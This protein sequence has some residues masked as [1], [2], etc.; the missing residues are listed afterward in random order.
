[1]EIEQ[2]T[3]ERSGNWGHQ[4][5]NLKIPRIK[6]KWKHNAQNL[7]DIAKAILRE[8]FIT[9]SDNLKNQTVHK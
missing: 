3:F 1:M 9:M 6:W 4:E 2:Y 8:K 5:G 7:W